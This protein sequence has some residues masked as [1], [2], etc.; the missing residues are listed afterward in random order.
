MNTHYDYFQKPGLNLC[1][2]LEPSLTMQHKNASYH[3]SLE[4]RAYVLSTCT[5]STKQ[6]IEFS[7]PNKFSMRAFFTP[8]KKYLDWRSKLKMRS[9]QYFSRRSFTRQVLPTEIQTQGRGIKS[10]QKLLLLHV[11]K[12][13]KHDLEINI[14]IQKSNVL[15]QHQLALIKTQFFSNYF[16][17]ILF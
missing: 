10:R 14:P 6:G 1:S 5:K 9:V 4:A 16:S 17:I 13:I 3:F 11:S 7:K 8:L 12:K 15:R 2:L